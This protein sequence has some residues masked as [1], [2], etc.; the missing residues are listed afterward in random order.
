MKLAIF[1][2]TFFPQING[3]SRVLGKYL[4]YMDANGIEYT[5]LVPEKEEQSYNGT[6]IGF[7]G[8]KFPLYPE[9]K[10]SV[11]RHAR[12]KKNLEILQP[13]L[14][15][16]ITPF[17]MGLAGM[18]YAKAHDLP[19]ITSY[20]T[21]FDQYLSH[22][23]LPL[24]ARPVNKYMKWFHS[25]SQ[26]NFCPSQETR[27]QLQGIGLRNVEICPNGVDIEM[28]SPEF[29]NNQIRKLLAID[30]QTPILLYVGRIAPE[31]GLN[32]LM[33]AVAMLNQ[34]HTP[35]KLVM[36]GDGPMREKLVKAKIDN[37][38]FLGY[39][40][41]RALQEIYA[42][43]DLFVFPSATETFGNV[44][45]EAMCSGLPVVAARAGGVKDNVIDMYNGITFLPDDPADMAGSIQ[46]LV[47][48]RAL[49]ANMK[50]NAIVY[51]QTKTWDEIFDKFFERLQNLLANRPKG[52]LYVA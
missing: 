47:K 33:K 37:V 50:V 46:T 17:S 34:S 39:K 35:F 44:V 31:K 29:R 10:I 36:V 45:L 22:Y 30:E 23:H 48:D 40:T 4:E 9:L 32:V 2:D 42:S 1:S 49:L 21:N 24:L 15:H 27:Q 28:F 26:I 18:K 5:L 20:H 12:M 7:G 52:K 11:P 43:A 16:L 19:I 3:V 13:D 8:V 51:A 25:F 38:V 41:G 6:I 14:I